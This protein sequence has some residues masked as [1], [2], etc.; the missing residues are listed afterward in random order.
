MGMI[1]KKIDA[2]PDFPPAKRLLVE[3]LVLSHHGKYEYGSPKLPMTP[4]AIMLHYL[5]DLDAKMQ[6]VRAEFTRNEA[7]G[8]SGA[9]MTDWIRS[10][11]RP[12]LDTRAFLDRA[13][14]DAAPEPGGTPEPEP[15]GDRNHALP[16]E[17]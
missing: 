12:L 17:D 1:E 9:E 16:F 10:L 4:E 3:H 14:P 7:S 11:E 15:E 8:R 13:L 5:D 6:T 2:I